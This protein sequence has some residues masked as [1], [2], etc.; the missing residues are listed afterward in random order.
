[1]VLLY[2][3]EWGMKMNDRLAIALLQLDEELTKKQ[4]RLEI[5]I[6]GAYA[7]QL[8]GYFRAEHTLDVDS[9]TQLQSIEIKKIIESI[10][11]KLNL[12]PLWLNDQASTVS[13]PDGILSR[14]K[15]I[16]N[17]KSISASLV[18]RPD[19]IKMKASAFSIRRDQTNKDW[20]D[21]VLLKPTDREIQDA[22]LFIKKT[23][24]PPK[25]ASKKILSEFEETIRDLKKIVK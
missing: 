10:G 8:S 12:G 20:E 15:P 14:A 7:L 24:S 3:L 6:C 25:N 22:I 23:N 19:L 11:Q 1:M 4:L 9:I 21:L 5:V 13:L 17:W 18:S 2:Y 16:G